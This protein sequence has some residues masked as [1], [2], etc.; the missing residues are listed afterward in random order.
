MNL[1][2]L[3]DWP[4]QIQVLAGPLLFF[5]ISLLLAG[6]ATFAMYQV[7]QT[8]TELEESYK[9]LT[10]VNELS[11][12]AVDM[13]TGMRGYDLSHQAS[14]L[15]PYN[16]AS[17]KLPLLLNNLRAYASDSPTQLEQI[18]LLESRIS[19]WQQTIA[20]PRI[21]AIHEGRL[22]ALTL[23]E[24]EEG[25]SLFDSIRATVEEIKAAEQMA[26]ARHAKNSR[27]AARNMLLGMSI[28]AVLGALS[29][30]ASWLIGRRI[31]KPVRLLG[32]A[33]DQ[34]AQND[35]SI[36][37]PE[38]GSYELARTTRAFNQMVG[39]LN[40]ARSTLLDQARALEEQVHGVERAR[41]EMDAVL[42]SV[43]DAIFLVGTDH[44][45][46]WANQ[47]TQEIFGVD[48][49][50][51][52]KFT[53]A[54]WASAF[55]KV[56]VDGEGMRSLV[57]NAFE[58][59]DRDVS[60]FV[61]IHWPQPRELKMFSAPVTGQGDA[62]HGRVFAFRDVTKEREVDRMKTDFVSM[63]SHEFR[64][65]LT[66]IK[67]YTDLLTSG[68]VGE[69]GE[70]QKEFLQIVQT[71]ADRLMALVN[72]L[73]DISRLE[74]GRV[75]LRAVT[76]DMVPLIQGAL[77]AQQLQ[78]Q[79]KQQQVA[80]NLASPLPPVR[81]DAARIAQIM[82]NLLSNA[83]KYTSAGG[84]ITIS[85]A[86]EGDF[87]RVNVADTGVGLSEEEQAHLFTR[88]YRAKNAATQDVG[89]TGLGLSITHMLVEMHGGKICVQSQ[90]GE[91]ATFSFTLPIATDALPL[92]VNTMPENLQGANNEMILIVEDEPDMAELNR[93]H[94][95]HAGYHV[96]IASNASEGLEM[97][98]LYSPD[99]I[100]L[101]VLL[102][103]TDGLTLLDW[104]KSDEATAA[105]PVLLLSIL[106]DDGQGRTLGAV[107]YLNKPVTSDFLL[108]HI[109]TVFATRRSPLILLA[110]SNLSESEHI[111]QDL[112]RGGY[113]TIAAATEEEV[114]LAVDE[115]Q[116]DLLMLDLQSSALDALEILRAVRSKENE[117]HLPVIFMAGITDTDSDHDRLALESFNHAEFLTK[118]FSSEEL[119]MLIANQG[120]RQREIADRGVASWVAQPV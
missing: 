117:N 14:F 72:D 56:F 98:K 71:N 4:I 111:R 13:E 17:I 94:L 114:L 90:A 2:R 23:T 100:L 60:E 107:D 77:V 49:M 93:W 70:D 58:H 80:V 21:R 45:V 97:A 39:A 47:R 27:Q 53:S 44:Q 36:H 40:E 18:D 10:N 57:L 20:D 104:L 42:N 38:D 26:L 87:L 30:L 8:H 35:Y 115:Q 120:L 109:R 61:A 6:S 29:L 105:I 69:I 96:L 64:T 12:L 19:E 103:G 74:Q 24:L 68:E 11:K 81:G 76:V 116:P 65:P 119:A 59:P 83:Y 62:Y 66:S 75:E 78:F 52:N 15:G 9:F 82:T 43:Q 51:M 118:P 5:A 63:V 33:A 101:D 46:L 34:V 102:P 1:R 55:A 110:D 91:G 85:A 25:K 112:H 86:R 95:T 67:G 84:T 31:V 48:L 37:L 79:S 41:S 32:S 113:R 106:P 28:V 108:A 89:G 16:L 73:L 92:V 88:F 50:Q 99:L 7:Q 3:F 54:E 22:P